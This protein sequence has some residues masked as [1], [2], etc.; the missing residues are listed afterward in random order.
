MIDRDIEREL[1]PLLGSGEEILWAARPQTGIKLRTSDAVM[2]PFSIVWCGFSIFWVVMAYSMDAPIPF[3]LF[4]VPFVFIG[5]YLVFGRFFA[6]ANR[7]AKTIYAF[8]RERVIIR[9]GGGNTTV[10]SI[11]IASLAELT[12]EQKADGSGTILLRPDIST[13]GALNYSHNFN[14]SRGPAR[15]VKQGPRLEMIDNVQSVYQRLLDL[16]RQIRV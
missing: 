3:V 9:T 2:I 10:E 14:S 13:P 15:Y 1:L 16:Q 6:D 8:T 5:L 4:G 12:L 11:P 7:R